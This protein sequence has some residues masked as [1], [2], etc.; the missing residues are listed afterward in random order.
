MIARWIWIWFWVSLVVWFI[1]N[2]F[3]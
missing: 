3:L 2:K 1:I